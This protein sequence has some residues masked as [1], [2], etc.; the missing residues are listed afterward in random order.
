MYIGSRSLSGDTYTI[1]IQ[2]P[3]EAKTSE[4]S[5]QLHMAL[6]HTVKSLITAYK[7]LYST[8]RYNPGPW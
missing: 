2:E 8:V 5:L 3:V 7:W 1:C 4:P 6:L